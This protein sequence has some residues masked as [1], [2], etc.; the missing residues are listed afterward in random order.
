MKVETKNF[1][2]NIIS[3]F[4]E[5]K[6]AIANFSTPF[7]WNRKLQAL[8][9][10]K[11]NPLIPHKKLEDYQS[12]DLT[13]VFS[14]NYFYHLQFPDLM[15]NTNDLFSCDVPD[16]ET[17]TILLVNGWFF[18]HN[19]EKLIQLPSG[20]IYG[21]FLEAAKKYP[22]VIE[23][24]CSKNIDTEPLAVINQ[25][26]SQDGFFIYFPDNST[27]DKPIQLINLVSA[28]NPVML[29][30]KNLFIIGKN[31]QAKIILCEHSIFPECF[32]NNSVLEVFVDEYAHLEFVRMQNAHNHSVQLTTTRFNQHK[33]STVVNNTVTL[34]GGLVRNNIYGNLNAE[35]CKHEMYGLFLVDKGQHVDNFTF[36][37]HKKPKSESIELFKGILDDNASAS[38]TGRILVEKNAQQTNAFQSNK[39]I[40]LTDDAKMNT[41]PQLEIYADDVKCSHGAAVGQIDEEALFYLRSR[42]IYKKDA[43]LMLVH[44]FAKEIIEKISVLPLKK[45]L[46]TLVN[47]RLKGDLER[48]NQCKIKC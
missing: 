40:L 11:K 33:N 17:H 21:S 39:N 29:F 25:I 3:L 44:A 1:G 24:Y 30:P 18:N 38:F 19:E 7:I 46:N 8:D 6:K 14:T 4:E 42:G 10:F 22:E 41:K 23:A 12:T 5:N 20:V 36:I 47:K 37:N 28:H 48:C 45:E 16:L 34:H 31:V 13:K 27:L 43:R 32:L 2:Q 35:H 15:I 9:Y 26:F